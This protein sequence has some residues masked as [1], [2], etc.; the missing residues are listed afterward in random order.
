MHRLVHFNGSIFDAQELRLSPTIGGVNYGWGVFTSVRIYDGEPFAFEKHWERLLRHADQANIKFNDDT[1][2]GRQAIS[3]LISANS[4]QD[5]RAR[6]LV[7]KGEV[8]GW[9][10]TTRADSDFLIFTAD[11]P[12]PRRSDL[13]LTLSP[14][15]ILSSSPLAGV[16][17]T[18]MLEHLLSFE[19]ARER[20]FSDAIVLNESGDIVS[21][22]SGNIFWVEADELMTPGLA[23][24]CVSGVTRHLVHSIAERINIHIVEGAYPIQRLLDAS[25]AFITSSLRGIAPVRSFDLKHYDVGAMTR[26]IS[27]EFQKLVGDAR[28]VS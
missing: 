16:K 26:N 27:R 21:A 17:R 19:E 9:R 14:Y 7:L 11:E 13:A 2:N 24:G 18:S 10:I 15:R 5:G 12:L 8:G 23:T 25:E 3:E 22:S 28:I 20:G 6:L 1:M 4:V